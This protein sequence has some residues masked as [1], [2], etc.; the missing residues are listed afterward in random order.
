MKDRLMQW[1]I[2]LIK[3]DRSY[4]LKDTERRNHAYK[5]MRKKE[6]Q[7]WKSKKQS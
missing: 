5:Q 7:R 1:I 2:A 3:L 6:E 4:F